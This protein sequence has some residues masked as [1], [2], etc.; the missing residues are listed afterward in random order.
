MCG[1]VDFRKG[2]CGSFRILGKV[3]EDFWSDTPLEGDRILSPIEIFCRF[4]ALCPSRVRP[5]GPQWGDNNNN[6]STQR[7]ERNLRVIKK[8]F[9]H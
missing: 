5:S 7:D 9:R 3:Y 4:T 2:S 8:A 6:N 1:F